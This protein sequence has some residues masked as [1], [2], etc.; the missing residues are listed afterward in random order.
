MLIECSKLSKKS[1][2]E[3]VPMTITMNEKETYGKDGHHLSRVEYS[4]VPLVG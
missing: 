1:P 3:L 4:E 2:V